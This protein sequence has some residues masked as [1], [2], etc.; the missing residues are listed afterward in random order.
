MDN[1]G[2]SDIKTKWFITILLPFI[3]F[4]A[5]SRAAGIDQSRQPIQTKPD[6]GIRRSLN[7]NIMRGVFIV[8]SPGL[9]DPNFRQTVVLLIHHEID[10][11][12]GLIINRPGS[13]PLSD[14]FP[15]IKEH[16]TTSDRIFSG[17]PV[18]PKTLTLLFQTKRP[19]MRMNPVLDNIY[20]SRKTDLL[21]ELPMATILDRH[22]RIY[23]GYAGWARGQLQAEIGRG[24]W[25]VVRTGPEIIFE[26]NTDIIWKKMLDRSRARSVQWELPYFHG[27]PSSLVP[28]SPFYGWALQCDACRGIF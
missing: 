2:S 1:R 24:D 10:G 17:G 12:T 20:I 22:F 5:K 7:T 13:A 6:S 15:V 21:A 3:L 26:K 27:E 16:L 9:I 18:L 19:P 14:Q 4:V 23:S 11:S 28:S 25:R 8:A